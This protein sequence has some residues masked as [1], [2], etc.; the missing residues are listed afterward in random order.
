MVLVLAQKI[1]NSIIKILNKDSNNK[2]SLQL[3]EK[4]KIYTL[5]LLNIN[6]ILRTKRNL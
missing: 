4:I 2:D 1:N 6:L 3:T 5:H